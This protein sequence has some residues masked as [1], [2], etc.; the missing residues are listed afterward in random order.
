MKKMIWFVLLLAF[1]FSVSAGEAASKRMNKRIATC[2]RDVAERKSFDETSARFI[3][4]MIDQWAD[5]ENNEQK[6]QMRAARRDLLETCQ[7]Y[8]D[9]A[10]HSPVYY[11]IGEITFPEYLE[12]LAYKGIISAHSFEIFKWLANDTSAC[13]IVGMDVAVTVIAGVSAGLSLGTCQAQNGR[14]FFAFVPSAGVNVGA[15]VYFGFQS[16]KLRNITDGRKTKFT[17]RGAVVLGTG[18]VVDSRYDDE[19]EDIELSASGRTYGVGLGFELG[20]ESYEVYSL[21]NLKNNFDALYPLLQRT[22][23]D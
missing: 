10:K 11:P 4:Q 6:N 1:S 8:K 17:T 18:A 2:L 19:N 22:A 13:N 14:K 21:M 3:S 16:I 7:G 9:A 5:I 15:I 20:A 12:D 23:Q